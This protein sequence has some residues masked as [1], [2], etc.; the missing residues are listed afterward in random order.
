VF[1]NATVDSEFL[2]SNDLM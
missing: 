2:T 1:N